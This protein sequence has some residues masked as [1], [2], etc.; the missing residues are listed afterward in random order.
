ML[1]VDLSLGTPN[2]TTPGGS[3]WEPRGA[4]GPYPAPAG[5][6]IPHPAAESSLCCPKHLFPISKIRLVRKKLSGL[7]KLLPRF[8]EEGGGGERL[9]VSLSRT[10]CYNQKHYS[11]QRERERRGKNIPFRKHWGRCLC[12]GVLFFFPPPSLAFT[13][14]SYYQPQPQQINGV[15][16]GSVNGGVCTGSS[17]E[18]PPR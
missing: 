3:G 12:A 11:R 18:L 6:A 16:E 5:S 2:S 10:G 15:G 8:T 1:D 13:Q 17:P 9:W 7:F 14:S 4:P